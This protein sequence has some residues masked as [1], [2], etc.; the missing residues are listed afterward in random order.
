MSLRCRVSFVVSPRACRGSAFRT[1]GALLLGIAVY[2][3]RLEAG[4]AGLQRVAA[5]LN[6]PMFATFA[7]GD[8]TKLYIAER[9]DPPESGDAAAAIRILDLTTGTLSP[10]P[11]LTI[12]GLNNDGE[13]GLL[14]L[15]FHPDYQSNGKF[16]VNVT[17]NDSISDN[18]FSTYIREYLRSEADPNVADPPGKQVLTFS[19]PQPNH[20]GGWIGFGPRDGYLYIMTGDGGN[21]NDQGAGHSEPD[22]NAQDV[23]A[24]FLGKVLRVD[25]DRDDF[26]GDAARNYGIPYDRVDGD[27]AI[28]GNPFAPETPQGADP[29]GDDEIWAYGLRNPFRAGFDRA[30]ADLWIGDVGQGAREEI[31]FQPGDSQGGE[32]YGWRFREG[33]IQTPGSVGRPKPD[34][35]VDPI[36]DYRRPGAAGVDPNLT[37]TTVTGGVA[38]RGPDPSLQGLYFFAD[39]SANRVWTLKL[40]DGESGLTVNYVNPQLAPD[41]GSPSTP[42]AISEDAVGNLY[43]TYLSGSVYRIKTDLFMSGD[44][45]GD[46]AVDAADLIN[47]SAGLGAESDATRADGDADGDGDVDGADFLAWQQNYGWSP[48]TAISQTAAA[49]IPEP[50]AVLLAMFAL[51]AVCRRT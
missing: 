11:F 13:G 9:G 17:A 25:V 31:D 22:G 18:A 3:A 16:Y 4:I 35:N 23:T 41:V 21:S 50:Q 6:S 40:P 43:I 10:T 15:A 46:A 47:W 14:G 45:N 12:T 32:N 36:Y 48:L 27:R 33:F 38:Y 24:N 44:F 19:Q 7:P 39:S 29:E 26:A 42:V 34:D 5:N 28:P 30:T 20:N 1:V 49:S 37:G 51:A 8:P 2:P